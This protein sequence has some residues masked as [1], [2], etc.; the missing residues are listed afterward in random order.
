MTERRVVLALGAVA[1]TGAALAAYYWVHKPLTPTQALAL[2]RSVVNLAVAAL[3]TVLAGAVGRRLRRGWGGEDVAEA[4]ERV[5]IDAALGWGGGGLVFLALGLAGLYYGL[6]AWGLVIFGVLW[7]RREAGA[8]LHDLAAAV[9]AAAPPDGAARLAAVVVLITLA[10]GL[11]RALAPPVM[12]DALVYHLTLPKLYAQGHGLRLAPDDFSLFTG[13]PQISEM[14]YTAAGLL[15]GDLPGEGAIAAQALGWAFGALAALAVASLAQA[16][17]LTGIWAAAVLLSSFTVA[18]S[19]AWA[20][21]DL[22]LVV[23]AA[24]MLAALRQWQHRSRPGWLLLAGVYGGLA[25]GCKYT[26]LVVPLAGAAAA[27]VIGL[28]R[29]D[30]Q[31]GLRRAAWSGATVLLAAGLVFSPWLLKN[32]LF[33]GSPVYP[34]LWPAADMDALRQWFYSRPDAAER[35]WQA[36][37]IFPRATFFGVQGGNAYDVTLGPL[38]L[39]LPLVLLFGWSRLPASMRAE[40]RL[41]LV[42]GAVGYA[43]WVALALYSALATQARLFFAL[44][45]ALAVLGVG[46]LAAARQLDTPRLRLSVVLRGLVVFVLGLGGLE[47]LTHFVSQNPMAYLIGAQTGAEYRADRLGWYERAMASVN[48]LPEESRIV[49]LWETRSLTCAEAVRCDPDVVIDRWWHLRR[50]VGTAEAIVQQWREAGATHVLIYDTGARFVEAEPRSAFEPADWA[51]LEALR[52]QLEL[53]EAF[54]LVYHLYAIP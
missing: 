15:R 9:R 51:E 52:G 38:Y 6:A 5:I 3:L 48:A 22:L 8:W 42:F 49:F 40:L 25:W 41:M 53:V 16:I 13:M 31:Q 32:W 37:A 46:G 47:T 44:L 26:G 2:A 35:G 23:F 29:A 19:L 30:G 20:Y 50:T 11:L 39:L 17:G 54:S 1:V 7:L 4:G 43:A 27:A 34:L 36:L 45:P 33:T 24:A 21:G 12:W 14:L 28:P 10:L 18:L